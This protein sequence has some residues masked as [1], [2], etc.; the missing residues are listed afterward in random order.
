M[1]ILS[2]Y[3]LKEFITF[4]A[5]CLLA[6]IVIF[7]L[8]DVVDNLDDLIDDKIVI[9][10]I[11]LYY[12][13]YLPY[14]LILTVPISM[15]L[16]TMF[17]LGRLLGDNEI[18]AMKASG[19]SLYR[20]LI[21]VYGFALLVGF[22]LMIFAEFVVPQ[23]NIYREDI[24]SQGNNFRLTLPQNRELDRSHVFVAD[25]PERIVYVKRYATEKRMATDVFIVEEKPFDVTIKDDTKNMQSH[26]TRR[27]DADYMTFSNGF[28][29]LIN[30]EERIF[31]EEG[32]K[33]TKRASMPM[34]ELS[35]KPSDLS[36][37][38]IEPDQM[39][40]FQLRDYI[41]GIREK[42]GDASQWLV[43][44]YIKISFPF[45]SFVIVFFG[46]PMVAGSTKRSKAS[47]FGIALMICF[48][49]YSMINACQI[50]G[51]NGAIEPLVAAWA[52]NGIFL[53]VGSVLH[54]KAR[55]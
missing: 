37:I 33:F 47:A 2:R 53:L 25:N 20:V 4:L 27:I 12:V 13:F 35:I 50:L 36:R 8:I 34:P 48:I 6:F 38:V 49:Y 19:I 39:N 7:I 10:L 1:R 55:K 42:G 31:T 5:Y 14:M 18:T 24:K 3:V 46:A 32:E 52:P 22:A 26:I 54:L 29:T 51:R 15:L 28:W 44:L 9:N 45:V 41:A 11:V 40:Y 17:S 21:P 16:T 43:D 23:A 30:V